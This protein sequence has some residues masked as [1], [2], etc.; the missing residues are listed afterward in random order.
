[1]IVEKYNKKEE[2]GEKKLVNV[3]L[4]ETMVMCKFFADR[5]LAKKQQPFSHYHN[6]DIE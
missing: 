2:K 5:L 6:R 1:M 3:F 4:S